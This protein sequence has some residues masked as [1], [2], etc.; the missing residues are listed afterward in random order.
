MLLLRLY[1]EFYSFAT[2]GSPRKTI[3][4]MMLSKTMLNVYITYA[5]K[6]IA[7]LG[8]IKMFQTIV[9]YKYEPEY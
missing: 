5:L 1:F 3:I 8:N 4:D 2:Q 7:Q 6:Y 9:N